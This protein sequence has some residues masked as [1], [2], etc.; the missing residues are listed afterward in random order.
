MFTLYFSQQNCLGIGLR[1]IKEK[2]LFIIKKYKAVVIAM[3]R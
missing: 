3:E 2:V 1:Q